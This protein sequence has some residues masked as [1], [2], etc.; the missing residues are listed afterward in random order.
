MRLVA[1]REFSW[2]TVRPR[3]T[4]IT[5]VNIRSASASKLNSKEIL[6]TVDDRITGWRA[7][8]YPIFAICSVLKPQ[9]FPNRWP[10]CPCEFR[11]TLK[12][13]SIPYCITGYNGIASN[14]AGS[15]VEEQLVSGSCLQLPKLKGINMYSIENKLLS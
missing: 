5:V 11:K 12:L 14:I 3:F 6:V 8:G 10:S 2:F 15:C 9:S 1:W 4:Y 13:E 7:D